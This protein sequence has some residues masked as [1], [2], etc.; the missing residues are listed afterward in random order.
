MI[1]LPKQYIATRYPGYFWNWCEE[2]LY[3]LKMDGVLTPLQHYRPN[4]WNKF[5][6]GGGYVVSHKACRRCLPVAY[7]KTLK[8]HDHVIPEQKKRLVK[9]MKENKQLKLI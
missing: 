5:P 8:F 2:R 1:T 6:D 9:P 3:S 7:L 4:R